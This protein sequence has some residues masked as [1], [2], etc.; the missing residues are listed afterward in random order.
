[1]RLNKFKNT[2]MYIRGKLGG[3]LCIKIITDRRRS[4]HKRRRQPPFAA[5]ATE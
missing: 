3:A 4:T 1:M 5:A 2:D